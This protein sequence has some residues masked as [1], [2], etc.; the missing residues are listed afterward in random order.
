MSHEIWAPRLLDAKSG[1]MVLDLW[2]G[3]WDG[4]VEWLEGGWIRVSIREYLDDGRTRLVVDIDRD[5]GVFRGDGGKAQGIEGMEKKVKAAFWR[6]AK[7]A[8]GS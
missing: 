8:G 7:R 6:K 4:W 5:G 1:E 2:D 3:M